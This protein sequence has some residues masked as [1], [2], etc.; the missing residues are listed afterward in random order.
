MLRD[1]KIGGSQTGSVLIVAL[2]FLLLFTI[3]GIVASRLSRTET[4]TSNHEK[5][6]RLAFY[7]AES[8][9][10][11]VRQNPSLYGPGNMDPHNPIPFHSPSGTLGAN[12]SFDGTVQYLET[13]L[14]PR[15]SG[16]DVGTF[17]AY[18]YKMICN[19]YGPKNAKVTIEAGFYRIGY[20]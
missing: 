14:P 9:R 5:N 4:I 1:K 12:Q 3:T 2:F 6:H 8:A 17:R 10:S 13:S 20:K 19:G 7:A 15:G 16:F 18:R 11:Y